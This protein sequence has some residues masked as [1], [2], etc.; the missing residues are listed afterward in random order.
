MVLSGDPSQSDTNK[1]TDLIKFTDAIVKHEISIP[2]VYFGVN[3]IV[4]SGI[5]KEL[6]LMFHAENW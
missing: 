4:R 3:D 5:A 2:I 1:G 6:A